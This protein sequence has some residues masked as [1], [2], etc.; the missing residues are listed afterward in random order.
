MEDFEI[1]YKM[2]INNKCSIFTAEAIAI[3]IAI[4]LIQDRNKRVDVLILTDSQSIC[5]ALMNNNLNIYQNNFIYK[6]R[7][8]IREYTKQQNKNKEHKTKIV[9]G[10]IPSHIKIKDNEMVDELAKEATEEKQDSRIK[11][12]KT[13][14]KLVYK[15]DMRVRTENKLE[16]EGQYIKIGSILI[17]IMIKTGKNR[18][19]KI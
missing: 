9:I 13:D 2:S 16:L 10:Q 1:G 11:I 19:L 17:N 12:P 8:K 7:Q 15:E 18:G 3:E 14:W 6:I 5:K 4:G